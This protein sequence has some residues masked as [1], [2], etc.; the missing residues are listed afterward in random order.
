MT[1][2]AI[3]ITIAIVAICALAALILWAAMHMPDTQPAE[4]YPTTADT[5]ALKWAEIAEDFAP[6]EFELL[7]RADRMMAGAEAK[8]LREWQDMPYDIDAD[9]GI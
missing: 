9:G 3:C 6:D 2:I 5:L 1:I 8:V 4:I 7:R